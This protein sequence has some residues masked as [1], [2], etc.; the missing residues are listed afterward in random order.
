MT[1]D[2][3]AKSL[4]ELDITGWTKKTKANYAKLDAMQLFLH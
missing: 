2:L 3:E 4:K 1:F